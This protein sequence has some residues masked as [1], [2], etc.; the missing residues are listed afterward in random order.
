MPLDLAR[1]TNGNARAAHWLAIW[2]EY[3]RACDNIVDEELWDAAHL[4]QCLALGCQCYSHPF[5]VEHR[6]SLQ[7]AALIATSLWTKSVEWERRPELWM[8]QWADVLR[9]ADVVI[10]STVA[11]LCGGGWDGAMEVTGAFLSAGYIDHKDRRGVPE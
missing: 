11:L 7:T 5:Y 1:V 6:Q 3:L 8:R 10:L 4:A 2:G 9:H